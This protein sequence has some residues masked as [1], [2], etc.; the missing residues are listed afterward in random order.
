MIRL[1]RRLINKFKEKRK[2]KKS[3]KYLNSGEYLKAERIMDGLLNSNA[4]D[5]KKLY[6]NYASALIANEKF[7]QAK[8]YLKKAINKDKSVDFFWGTLAEVN[9]LKKEWKHAEENLKKAIELE[10]N[11]KIYQNKLEIVNGNKSVKNNYLNYY[12]LIK[13]AIKFQKEEK[14]KKSIELF[15]ESLK[16]YDKMGYAYNQIGAIYNNNLGQK[17]KALKYFRLALEK[18]PNNKMFKMNLKRIR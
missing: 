15:K 18:E 2:F 6:F 13:K 9:I 5:L 12:D 1:I 7:D 17:E 16:Y 4:L 8:T 3:L 11:K 10:P 14:W